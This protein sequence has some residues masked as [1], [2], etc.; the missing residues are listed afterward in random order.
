MTIEPGLAPGSTTPPC[1]PGEIVRSDD[2]KRVELRERS[3]SGWPVAFRA[4]RKGGAARQVRNL[5]GLC[6]AGGPAKLPV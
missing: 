1:V 5:P 2:A 3:G 4:P 6:V